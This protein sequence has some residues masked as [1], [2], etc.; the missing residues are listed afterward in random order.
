M[1]SSEKRRE[2]A[3]AYRKANP[4]L[5]KA[6]KRAEYARNR[7]K[8]LARVKAYREENADL[9]KAQKREFYARNRER[10]LAKMREYRLANPEK[11]SNRRRSYYLRNISA[12]AE[13]CRG[14]YA[15]NRDKL[16]SYIQNYQL[17]RQYGIGVADKAELLAAQGGR[18]AICG[19]DQ[20]EGK[21]GWQ[22]DHDHKT[23]EVRGCLCLR[24]NLGL[25]YSKDSPARLRAA[26]AYLRRT[27]YTPEPPPSAAADG[28][29]RKG[30]KADADPAAVQLSFSF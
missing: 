25:G 16:R 2:Y 24:C 26:A 29:G 21:K 4:E 14:Y 5:V 8:R 22:I 7:E 28:G 27:G 12:H 18:C 15:R 30:R 1:P 20:P 9:V 6:Q 17:Q 13:Y 3:K 11:M 23:G 10:L 19:T